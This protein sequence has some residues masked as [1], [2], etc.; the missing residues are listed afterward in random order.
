M[1]V[2]KYKMAAEYC[3]V[4]KKMFFEGRPRQEILKIENCTWN[5]KANFFL[6][7]IRLPREVPRICELWIIDGEIRSP[8]W[9]RFQSCK[10]VADLRPQVGRREKDRYKRAWL[11]R[12]FISSGMPICMVQYRTFLVAQLRGSIQDR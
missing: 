1:S 6:I 5:K 2:N 11:L 7:F 4:Q 8:Y 12:R 3:R 9:M 10:V